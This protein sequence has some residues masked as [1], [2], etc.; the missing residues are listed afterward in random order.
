MGG[1]PRRGPVDQGPKGREVS[2]L[3]SSYHLYLTILRN[4]LLSELGAEVRRVDQFP[5]RRKLHSE[6][7]LFPQQLVVNGQT[8]GVEKK[9]SWPLFL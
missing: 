8:T 5:G 2:A 3:P 9:L 4:K 6:K 1:C 7:V